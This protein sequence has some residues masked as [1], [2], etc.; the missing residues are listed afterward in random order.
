M[1][2]VEF[3]DGPRNVPDHLASLM[4]TFDTHRMTYDQAVIAANNKLV[5]D[6]LNQTQVQIIRDHF[7]GLMG[8]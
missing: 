4:I 1:A 7:K 3:R 5:A 8:R 6:Q 2:E